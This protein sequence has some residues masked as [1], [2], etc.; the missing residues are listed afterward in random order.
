MSGSVSRSVSGSLS[1]YVS[2]SVS[3]SVRTEM[4]LNHQKRV[5]TQAIGCLICDRCVLDM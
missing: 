5:F 4:Q 3:G 1:R 2:G